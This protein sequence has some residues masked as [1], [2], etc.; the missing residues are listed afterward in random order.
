MIR[1]LLLS[2]VLAGCAASRPAAPPA[3]ALVPSIATPKP[4][5]T[6]TLTINPPARPYHLYVVSEDLGFFQHILPYRGPQ[7][8][9]LGTV[10]FRGAGPHHFSF[11]CALP[12]E[13]PIVVG[14]PK[15]AWT[16]PLTDFAR[17]RT[18][19][20]GISAT[21]TRMEGKSLTFHVQKHGR[22]V[23]DFRQIYGRYAGFLASC[24][25]EG[26]HWSTSLCDTNSG[27]D[28]QFE[29]DFRGSGIHVAWLHFSRG[30]PDTVLPFTVS[31]Q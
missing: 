29:H 2:C 26:Q 15:G 21:L 27:P 11:D 30:G 1:L 14:G 17:T 22:P 20:G 10:V 13:V 12:T 8:Q 23:T 6:V 19:E 24:D 7:G 5:D 4:T 28:L 9:E 3:A 16:S 31:V 18:G 25:E